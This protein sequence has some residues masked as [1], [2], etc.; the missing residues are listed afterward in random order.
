MGKKKGSK[1]ESAVLKGVLDMTRSG[2]GYVVVED[3]KEDILIK[4]N[5]INRAFDGDTVQV[6]VKE[7]GSKKRKEGVIVGVLER[8]QVKYIGDLE[9]SEHF[10]FFKPA[11]EKP[12]PD[13]YISKENIQDAKNHDRVVVEF[14][15]W[16]KDEKKPEGKVIT[17]LDA[18]NAADMA[19][20]EIIIQN[21]FSL[22]FSKEVLN[23]TSHLDAV[24]TQQDIKERRD[25]REALTLTIDPF[26]AKDFDDA[27]SLVKLSEHE[28]EEV[29]S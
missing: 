19:M 8:K 1:Q 3:R 6:R 16:E 9:V 4:S 25:Y 13:F 20:K 10:A 22:N 23:E 11:G 27:L 21:G 15:K 24:P 18:I 29:G 12:I 28:F 2:M 7:D 26:D 14:L 17:I 5:D